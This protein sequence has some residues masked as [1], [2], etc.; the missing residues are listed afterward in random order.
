MLLLKAIWGGDHGVYGQ[1]S[2]PNGDKS[3]ICQMLTDASGPTFTV[4]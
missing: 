3:T 2:G 4:R 1:V